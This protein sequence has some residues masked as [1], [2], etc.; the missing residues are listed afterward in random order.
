MTFSLEQIIPWLEH[1]KYF[2]IFPLAF[3]EGPITTIIAGFLSSLGYLSFPISYIIIV[4][5]DLS[6]DVGYYAL[7]RWGR[8]KLIEKYGH[9]VGITMSRM[10][11]LESH[12]QNHGGKMLI[13]G[14]IADP[15]SSTVQTIA[16]ATKMPFSEFLY[17]NIISTFPKSLILLTAGFYFGEAIHQ[18]NLY[19]QIV[20]IAASIVGIVILFTY[21]IY[22][23]KKQKELEKYGKSEF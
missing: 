4:I 10:E 19:R 23:R 16:G 2:A 20:G 18:V 5:A 9:Y 12:F 7:G 21:F 17:Y 8:K 15:L 11:K 22:R 3:I 6:S 1:Y 14:K 13:F